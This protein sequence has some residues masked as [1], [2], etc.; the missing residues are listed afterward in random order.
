MKKL[1]FMT[2]VVGLAL[3]SCSQEE[4]SAP[5]AENN[6]IT[7]AAPLVGKNTRAVTEVGVNYDL[8]AKFGVWAKYNTEASTSWTAGTFYIGTA[9][10]NGV[11]AAYKDAVNGW[12]FATPYYWPKNGNLS[13]I[14]YSPS[15]AAATVTD[16]GIEF[17]NYT[18]G[19]TANVDLLFSEVARNKTKDNVNTPNF[20]V[21]YKGIELTF[22]HALSSV[23]FAV[24][25]KANYLGTEIK[26]QKIEVLNAYSKGNFNQGLEDNATAVTKPATENSCWS[27]HTDK[28]DYTA[29]TGD[30]TVGETPLY[31]HNSSAAA[32]A[33]TTDLILLPQTLTAGT[34]AQVKV[35]YT[36]KSPSGNVLPQTTVLNLTGEWLR[37]T[38]YTYTVVFGL[39]EIYLDPTVEEWKD[40]TDLNVGI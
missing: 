13:F 21:S 7:F 30:I 40:V 11:E 31:V 5:V 10:D 24:K 3:T 4:L 19:T 23:R 32:T 18:V 25:T 37:G 27:G 34:Q 29:F 15:T 35:T 26:V 1:F 22:K 6:E 39:D 36:I 38:R 12:G 33:N 28:I 8:A 17:A 16:N 2:A 14:A 9:G 20:P